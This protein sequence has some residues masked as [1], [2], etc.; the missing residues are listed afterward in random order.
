MVAAEAKIGKLEAQ[1]SHWGAKLD[2]LMGKAEADGA[3]AQVDYRRHLDE[4]KAKYHVA[5]VKLEEFKVAG[6]GKWEHFKIGIES[7]WGDLESAFK[8]L[9]V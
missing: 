5:R 1:L 6:S 3:E 4:L 8:A 2:E 7:A 9:K